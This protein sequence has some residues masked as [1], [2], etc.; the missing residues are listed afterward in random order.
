MVGAIIFGK[1]ATTEFATSKQGNIHQNLTAN[2]HD[3]KRTPGGSSSGSG[4]AIGDY[5]IPVALGTQTGGSIIRPASFNGCYGLKYGSEID[6]GI[7]P[8]D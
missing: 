7:T 8:L 3:S 4:A 6:F 2:P 1:T 5:Q